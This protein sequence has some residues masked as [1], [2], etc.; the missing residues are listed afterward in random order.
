MLPGVPADE[1]A[2]QPPTAFVTAAQLM[3][4]TRMEKVTKRNKKSVVFLRKEG[5]HG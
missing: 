1:G 3:F 5:S 2:F 4:V